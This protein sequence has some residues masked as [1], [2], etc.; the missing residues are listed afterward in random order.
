MIG[1]EPHQ[2]FTGNFRDYLTVVKLDPDGNQVWKTYHDVAFET[3]NPPYDYAIGGHFFTEEFGEKLLDLVV[4]INNETLLLKLLEN[5]GA[6]YTYEQISSPLIDV[7][8]NNDKVY[9]VTQCS[10]SAACYGPDSLTVQKFDPTPDSIIFNPIKWTYGVK[11]NIRTAPIQGHYDFDGQD[12]REDSLGN[13]YLL[14]QIERWDFQFCTDC[15]DAF[16]DAWCE[17]FKL[18]PQGQLLKHQ[19]IVTSRA[20]VSS[21]SFVSFN[22][23]E[24]IIRVDDINTSNTAIITSVYHVDSELKVTKTVKLDRQYLYIA[25]DAT[26]NLFTS[27]NIYD[28]NDPNIHGESD[29]LISKFNAEG[30][31]QWKS[32]LG[33]SAF[34]WPRG[35]VLTNDHDLVFLANTQSTDFDVE[36]NN[37]GQDM[38]VVRLRE[39]TTSTDPVSVA[40]K[41]DVYPNP[42]SDDLHLFNLHDISRLEVYDLYGRLLKTIEVNRDHVHVDVSDLPSGSYVVRGQSIEGVWTGKVYKN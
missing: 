12:I 40:G 35:L 17:V 26:G 6:Y 27:T 23:D 38:W 25:A 7:K 31:L 9:A 24:M 39:N 4:S 14:V 10:L 5:T 33:G 8:P 34:E 42:V 22:E 37:G 15:G 30:L 21:M 29:V 20:V 2:D 18:S 1:S 28:Q 3:F 19:R 32:Y 16:I 41:L 36:H 13:V 11:Q